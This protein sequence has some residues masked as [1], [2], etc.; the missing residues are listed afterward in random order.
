MLADILAY[1]YIV[2][3]GFVFLI[4]VIQILAFYIAGR[5]TGSIDDEVTSAFT[6]F[7]ALLI[8]GTASTLIN[9]GISMFLDGMLIPGIIA[10][11]VYLIAIIY[12]VVKIYELSIG[13]AILHLILSLIITVALTGLAVFMGIKVIPESQHESTTDSDGVFMMEIEPETE[14]NAI[15]EITGL[16]DTISEAE[17]T[18]EEAMDEVDEA[19]EE[20]GEMMEDAGVGIEETPEEPTSSGPGLPGSSE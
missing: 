15:D 19:M 20:A 1:S 8:I 13:K 12:A 6:L 11:I 5:V 16:E 14:I 7:G 3:V 2:I 17:D 10:F 4:M 9:A 18:L